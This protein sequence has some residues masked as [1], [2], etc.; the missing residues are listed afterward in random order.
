MPYTIVFTPE[1]ET[2]LTELYSY[3]AAEASPDIAA[4]FTDAS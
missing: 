2:Q 3:I 4:R 1:A